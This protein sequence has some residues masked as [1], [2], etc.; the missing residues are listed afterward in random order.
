MFDFDRRSGPPFTKYFRGI[1]DFSSLG[2]LLKLKNIFLHVV[3]FCTEAGGNY[4]FLGVTRSCYR[5]AQ[6]VQVQ[7][8]Y[9]FTSG[10]GSFTLLQSRHSTLHSTLHIP[11]SKLYNLRYILSTHHHPL[12]ALQ[13]RFSTRHC[14]LSTLHSPISALQFPSLHALHS[15]RSS[16]DSPIFTIHSPLFSHDSPL[17][18]VHYPHS[19]PHSPLSILCSPFSNFLHYLISTPHTPFKTLQCSLTT[20]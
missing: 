1:S 20:F 12:I 5:K 8:I 15:P 9:F 4:S 19:T 16:K 11:H 10:N 13:S 6:R 17:A 14:P 7:K 18:T 3:I 2:H